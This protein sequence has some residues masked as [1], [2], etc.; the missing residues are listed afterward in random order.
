MFIIPF[1]KEKKGGQITVAAEN[2]H[3]FLSKIVTYFVR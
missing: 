1:K 3:S 2:C